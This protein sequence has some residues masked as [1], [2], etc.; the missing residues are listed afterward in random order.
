MA[1]DGWTV[2]FGTA[3]RDR[4]GLCPHPVPSSLYHEPLYSNTVLSTLA[5]DGWTVTFGTARRDL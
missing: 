5:V 3:R 1:V 4:G 2:T